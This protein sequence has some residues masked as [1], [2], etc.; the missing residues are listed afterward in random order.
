MGS[1]RVEW[2]RSAERELRRLPKEAIAR[3]VKL[4]ASLEADPFPKGARKLTGAEHT[5]RL[6]AGDYRIVYSVEGDRLVV[7]I[8]RVSHRKEVYR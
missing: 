7:E 6:R 8:I 3:L 1:Y 2:K 5:W 4:A